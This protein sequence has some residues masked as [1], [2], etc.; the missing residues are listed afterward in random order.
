MN[1]TERVRMALGAS[2]RVVISLIAPADEATWS[3]A[4][5]IDLCATAPDAVN[6]SAPR[7]LAR[8]MLSVA[9]LAHQLLNHALAPLLMK[10]CRPMVLFYKISL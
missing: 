5:A 1:L 6:R 3:S 7:T 8:Q 10:T 9:S 2:A 4:G